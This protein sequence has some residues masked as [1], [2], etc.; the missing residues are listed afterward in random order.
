MT[1]D[2]VR[3]RLKE[4]QPAGTKPSHSKLL[5]GFYSFERLF[6]HLWDLSSRSTC[7]RIRIRMICF[8]P[9]LTFDFRGPGYKCMHKNTDIRAKRR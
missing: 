6:N 5:V 7:L 3:P 4:A 9:A 8:I 2:R 1:S